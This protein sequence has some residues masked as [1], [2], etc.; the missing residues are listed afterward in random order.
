MKKSL[1]YLGGPPVYLR[2][3]STLFTAIICC[4]GIS[5]SWYSMQYHTGCVRRI[6]IPQ[7][8]LHP[9]PQNLWIFYLH[10]RRGFADVIKAIKGVYPALTKWTQYNHKVI[11]RG[12]RRVRVRKRVKKIWWWNQKSEKERL[13]R[14]ER[15]KEK[16]TW[17]CCSVGF[18]DGGRGHKVKEC[19]CPRE[20]GKNKEVDFPLKPPEGM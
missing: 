5:S 9:N 1:L 6:M 2:T 18:E 8:Y 11:M 13:R 10:D 4:T 17:K 12:G 20:T 19:R 16:E 15:E 14:R 3:T 7:R